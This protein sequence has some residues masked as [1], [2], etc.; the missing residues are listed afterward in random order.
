MVLHLSRCSNTPALCAEFWAQAWSLHVMRTTSCDYDCLFKVGFAVFH[1]GG[2]TLKHH[3]AFSWHTMHA[4][5]KFNIRFFYEVP[6]NC[7]HLWWVKKALAGRWA[8]VLLLLPS[9]KTQE[10]VLAA[11]GKR[12]T[13]PLISLIGSWYFSK[14]FIL[15]ATLNIN[16]NAIPW[17]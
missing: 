5:T 8:F 16:V 15:H 9:H 13:G 10:R 4:V 1:T 7:C 6:Q 14:K 2:R 17:I 3:I 11:F 12:S